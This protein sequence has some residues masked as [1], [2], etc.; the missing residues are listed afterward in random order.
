MQ[1]YFIVA[2]TMGQGWAHDHPLFLNG[3][4]EGA[5]GLGALYSKWTYSY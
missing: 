2:D 1:V 5:H 4:H 3:G